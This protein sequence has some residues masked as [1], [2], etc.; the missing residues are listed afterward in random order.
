MYHYHYI[1]FLDKDRND[2]YMIFNGD[3]D[4]ETATSQWLVYTKRA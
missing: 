1:W 3:Y 2:L 4:R